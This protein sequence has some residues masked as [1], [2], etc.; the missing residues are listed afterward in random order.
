MG[1]D[2][3]NGALGVSLF[4]AVAARRR[5]HDGAFDLAHQSLVPLKT[6]LRSRNRHRLSRS[7]GIGGFLGLGSIVYGL[8]G[9]ADLLADPDSLACAELAAELIDA[10]A[11]AADQ[12]HDLVA[13]S[14]GAI[15]GLLK[16]Q[17]VTRDAA[18][19][20]QASMIGES[21]VSRSRQP[22]APWGSKTFDEQPLT[23]LSHG[24]SGFA[25]AFARLDQA[26]GEARF[27]SI[28]SDCLAFEEGRFD[29]AL[30]NWRDTR[31]AR[32]RTGEGSPN[33][34]CYGAAGIG[35]ARL[36][37][38]A[39]ANLPGEPAAND[40]SAAVRSV[41][42]RAPASNDTL[43]CGVAGHADFLAAAAED[44]A[45]PELLAASRALVSDISGRWL[46]DGDARWDLGERDFNLGFM[47]GVS[48]LGYAALRIE[49]PDLPRV[50]ILQ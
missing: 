47:R 39:I 28:V 16:L 19:L 6:A 23:G 27:E 12:Q 49:A 3:Y 34:W 45:Q 29:P 7:I 10:E 4:L 26:R 11:V 48:G 38:P 9:C 35:Y 13:G 24:A 17:G 2:L 5:N 36:G 41:L 18:L 37:L 43:C 32:M 44:L 33:Q 15:L 40:I 25:L 50:L 31:P 22:G 21:L 20:Q 42:A 1:Y 14:A 46:R 30:D 8:S